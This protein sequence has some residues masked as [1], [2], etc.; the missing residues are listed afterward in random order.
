MCLH[1]AQRDDYI[2]PP[3]LVRGK[4]LLPKRPPIATARPRSP[5]SD[6]T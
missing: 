2:I 3:N 1:N 4:D 6:E 5:E